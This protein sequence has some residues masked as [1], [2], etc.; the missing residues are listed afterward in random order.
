MDRLSKEI[1]ECSLYYL[2]VF[3]TPGQLILFFWARLGRSR[4]D[5]VILFH[6]AGWSL[7]RALS[8]GP[9]RDD[10]ALLHVNSGPTVADQSGGI[11]EHRQRTKWKQEKPA[12]HRKEQG[13]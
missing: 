10:P 9:T 2:Q 11:S 12:K 4:L 7:G 6:P 1:K 5:S 8:H 13:L 3:R